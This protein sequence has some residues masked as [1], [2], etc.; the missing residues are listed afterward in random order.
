L[1]V[2]TAAGARHAPSADAEEK[3]GQVSATGGASLSP[4]LPSPN[5]PAEALKKIQP[6]AAR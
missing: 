2:P 3:T 5:A 6:K 1:P 4:I